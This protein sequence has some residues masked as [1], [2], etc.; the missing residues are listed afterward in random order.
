ME[1]KTLKN[2]VVVTQERNITKAAEVLNMT[3]PN[4]SRKMKELENELGVVLFLRG[5]RG[6]TLTEDGL[7]LKQRVEEILELSDKTE[8]LFAQRGNIVNGTVSIGMAESLG[9]NKMADIMAGFSQKYPKVQYE[10][11]NSFAT[12]I[13]EKI[14]R[15]LL[16][17]G[18]ILHP[19]HLSKFEYMQIDQGERW[20]ILVAKTHPLAP[21][22]T[23]RFDDIINERLIL[24]KR[25]V[26]EGALY[27]WFGKGESDLDILAT[28]SIFSNTILLVERNM[29]CAICNSG[30]LVTRN[31]PNVVFIPLVPILT[32]RTVFIRKKERILTPTESL[33][34]Q[35]V[36]SMLSE[37]SV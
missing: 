6:I 13:T 2:F 28:Y 19:L 7:L 26:A 32:S 29:G 11:Y 23:A 18:I 5:K 1:L 12:D 4:L 20:G 16:A 15:G 30:F 35:Y 25:A 22:K 3:Q 21:R 14:D 17:F 37:K 10:C 31:N 27:D 8:Q 24:P 9:T 33:F 36:Q 34:L